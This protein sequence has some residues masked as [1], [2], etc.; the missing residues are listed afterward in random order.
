MTKKVV[1]GGSKTR[2][3]DK[4]RAVFDLN[5]NHLQGRDFSNDIVE[6]EVQPLIEGDGSVTILVH[7]LE[8]LC[9]LLG[10]LEGGLHSQPEHTGN[11]RCSV[12]YQG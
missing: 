4:R 12:D 3:N 8:D 7:L 2:T 9:P 6:A 11:I 1:G 5:N 10:G